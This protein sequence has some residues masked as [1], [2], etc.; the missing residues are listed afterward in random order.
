[1]NRTLKE[2]LQDGWGRTAVGILLCVVLLLGYHELNANSRVAK[3]QAVP[4]ANGDS[5]AALHEQV[6][7][8]EKKL[9]TIANAW[10][11]ELGDEP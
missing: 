5:L 8:L 3:L 11:V 2:K 7:R 6:D 4:R 9:N 10:N 1:M